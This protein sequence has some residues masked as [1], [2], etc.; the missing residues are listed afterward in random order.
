MDEYV[1]GGVWRVT[2]ALDIPYSN[3]DGYAGNL[4]SRTSLD[5]YDVTDAV[6]IVVVRIALAWTGDP[7][8][9]PGGRAAGRSTGLPRE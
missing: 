6:D 8:V 5:E 9:S 2:I 7:A 1:Q 4:G 3:Y